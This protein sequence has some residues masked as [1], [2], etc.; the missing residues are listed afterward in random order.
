MAER[1][2]LY[3]GVYAAAG[4]YVGM[5]YVF[6][7]YAGMTGMN[8]SFLLHKICL[9]DTIWLSGQMGRPGG[10][11]GQRS[12]YEA[13]CRASSLPKRTKSK[14]N[15]RP[16]ASAGCSWPN[17]IVKTVCLNYIWSSK[18]HDIG[19]S[20]NNILTPPGGR[21]CSLELILPSEPSQRDPFS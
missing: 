7:L 6:V 9:L 12:A 14:S 20:E 3:A 11:I 1:H 19:L 2:F 5:N 18:R 13:G 17:T 8:S 4:M 10:C 15:L 21:F 16:F